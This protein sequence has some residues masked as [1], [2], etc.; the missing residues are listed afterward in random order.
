MP[1]YSQD[2]HVFRLTTPLGKDVLLLRGFRGTEAVS[3]LFDLELDLV[4]ENESEVRFDSVVGQSVTITVDG[5][6]GSPVR[7]FNGLCSELEEGSRET[8]EADKKTFTTWRM[9]VVPKVAMLGLVH[10]SRVFQETSVSDILKRVF[11]GY[12]VD[13]DLT[14]TG[15]PPA[16][17]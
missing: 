8:L 12:E 5:P 11:A 7:W 14:A 6:D 13:Y 1:S 3:E 2:G 15:S 10:R 17:G 9:R 16:A 4:S